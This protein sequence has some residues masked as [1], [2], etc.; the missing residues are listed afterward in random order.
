[1]IFRIINTTEVGAR[2][3]FGK[4]HPESFLRP[5]LHFY[6]PV[7]QKIETL[8]VNQQIVH[9]QTDVFSKN[10][11]TL[12]IITQ[13]TVQPREDEEDSGTYFTCMTKISD[14]MDKLDA[15]V[16]D[17]LLK[18]A[19]KLDSEEFFQ[20]LTETTSSLHS[21]LSEVMEDIGYLVMD[22]RITNVE[23]EEAVKHANS[24][25]NEAKIMRLAE[26]EMAE[27][28]RLRIVQESIAHREKVEN[29]GIGIRNKRKQIQE[30]FVEFVNEMKRMGFTP[31]QALVFAVLQ[32]YTGMYSDL[33]ESKNAKVLMMDSDPSSF[34][35]KNVASLQQLMGVDPS[36]LNNIKN[37]HPS[38][39]PLNNDILKKEDF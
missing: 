31:Q 3:T 9:S 5:G 1:M 10:K 25:V 26:Q 16:K 33:A 6:F 32:G 15:T 27:A 12:N 17:Q 30:G 28:N 36:I 24:K 21:Q 2:F 4:L 20:N 8:K 18:I 13:V 7:V 34:I 19:Y 22:V 39:I 23:H 37:D 38:S 14:P 11:V 35:F 29:E